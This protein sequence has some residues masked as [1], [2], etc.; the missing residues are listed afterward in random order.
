[1]RR[2]VLVVV[3]ALGCASRA[4]AP[5]PREAAPDVA[6]LG[7]SERALLTDVGQLQVFTTNLLSDGRRMRVRGFVHNP[8]PEPVEGV[9]LALRL[10]SHADADASELERFQRVQDVPIAPGRNAPVHW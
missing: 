6:M 10:L 8:Y 9:R 2:L 3:V 4:P 7:P 1:M 5:G